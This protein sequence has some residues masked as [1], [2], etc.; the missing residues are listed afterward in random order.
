M[1]NIAGNL[2]DVKGVS[3]IK[4]AV[5]LQNITLKAVDLADNPC[6]ASAQPVLAELEQLL[7][8]NRV[9]K[10]APTSGGGATALRSS[11]QG[12]S[13]LHLASG[14]ASGTAAGATAGSSGLLTSGATFA[15]EKRLQ[16][17]EDSS[18]HAM[19]EIQHLRK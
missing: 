6:S 11:S 5:Q 18:A 8:R 10:K 17:L 4:Q 19:S 12:G 2:I 3:A 7:Q 1:N 9:I 13:I 16:A 14:T 15:V